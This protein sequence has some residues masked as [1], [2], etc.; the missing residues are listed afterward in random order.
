MTITMTEGQIDELV[1]VPKGLLEIADA[2]DRAVERLLRLIGD[3]I[4]PASPDPEEHLNER[5]GHG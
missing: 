1:E 3:L 5:R 2:I 4:G